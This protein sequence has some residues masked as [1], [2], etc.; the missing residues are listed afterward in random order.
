[1]PPCGEFMQ[2][3]I[4]SILS[5]RPPVRGLEGYTQLQRQVG[6]GRQTRFVL[7]RAR[8]LRV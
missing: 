4:A 7:V 5:D 2:D 1:M 3:G 6:A 8:G